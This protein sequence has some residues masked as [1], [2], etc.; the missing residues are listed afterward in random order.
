TQRLGQVPAV[1]VAASHRGGE[2]E[3]GLERRDDPADRVDV[4]AQVGDDR[5]RARFLVEVAQE[6]PLREQPGRR[7]LVERVDVELVDQQG[8][9][10][11][12]ELAE[13]AARLLERLH[14]VERHHGERCVEGR[15][16]LELVQGDGEDALAGRLRIDR[17]HLVAGG[18]QPARERPV[19]GPDLEHARGRRRKVR[20]GERPDLD[21]E[22]AR[23]P[24][25]SRKTASVAVNPCRKALPPT[26]PISPP[27]KNPASESVPSASA[28]TRASW[29]GSGNMFVPRPLHVKRS[30]P[31]GLTGSST[32]R[33]RRRSASAEPASRTKNRSVCPTLTVSPRTSAP[34]SSSAPSRPRMRK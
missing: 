22:H 6:P 34:L 16:V 7:A 21:G 8:P 27:Q 28:T 1:Q 18:G 19:A 12:D 4:L 11:P 24:Y 13:P 33:A 23:A 32:A 14:V 17:E 30:A 5:R 20:A 15:G 2:V 9:A 25:R 26:G 3:V 31:A 29:S 10:G